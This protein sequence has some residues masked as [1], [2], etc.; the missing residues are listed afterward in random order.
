MLKRFI[1]ILLFNLL[2]FT[3][4]S[5]GTIMVL[6]DSLSAGYGFDPQQGWVSLLQDQLGNDHKVINASVSG[7]TSGGGLHRLPPLLQAHTPDWVIIELGGNDGLRGYPLQRLR[8]NLEHIIHKA[9]A[10]NS[11]PILVAIQIPPNYGPRYS[12]QFTALYTELADKFDI[13]LVKNFID[14]VAT[15][16]ALMQN[17]GIHPNAKAQ[18]LL[19]EKILA[20]LQPQLEAF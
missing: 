14:L 11:N 13:P 8:Q 19:M 9:Q 6:G 12:Q 2:A 5:A 10:T 7:E 18:P 17:D 16:S 3:Q 1:F 4:A 20:T 15:D